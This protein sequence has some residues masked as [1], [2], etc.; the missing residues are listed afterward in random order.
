MTHEEALTHLEIAYNALTK[1]QQ[2]DSA[3]QLNLSQLN[4]KTPTDLED[5]L[6]YT[7]EVWARLEHFTKE[8]NNATTTPSA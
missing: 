8:Q 2:A 4:Y 1:V 5:A 6:H 3:R 7:N